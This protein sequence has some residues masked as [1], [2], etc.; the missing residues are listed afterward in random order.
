MTTNNEQS[1][2]AS[3]NDVT[4]LFEMVDDR[5]P[6]EIVGV[7]PTREQLPLPANESSAYLV[8]D[9]QRLFIRFHQQWC[10]AGAVSA[11]MDAAGVNTLEQLVGAELKIKPVFVDDETE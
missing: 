11:M 2:P 3:D 10:N 6:F 5:R 8:R 9:N 4:E 1:K 7:V